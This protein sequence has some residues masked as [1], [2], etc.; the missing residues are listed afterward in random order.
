MDTSTIAIIMSISSAV[1]AIITIFTN[2]GSNSYK[3]G[4]RWGAFSQEMKVELKYI[5]TD[6]E[7]IKE[8]VKS[9]KNQTDSA[10]DEQ[11]KWMKDNVN[12]IY[13]R[14][15]AHLE[16]EHDMKVPKRKS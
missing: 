14:L 1:I 5:R 3:D 7:E 8:T 10:L 13:D 12:R 2:R 6:L 11:R 15:D 4:E 16:D 9:T